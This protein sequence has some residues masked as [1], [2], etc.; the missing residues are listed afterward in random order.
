MNCII[1]VTVYQQLSISSFHIVKRVIPKN[2]WPAKN[3][4]VHKDR[5]R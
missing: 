4:I 3:A 5:L 2:I 1:T